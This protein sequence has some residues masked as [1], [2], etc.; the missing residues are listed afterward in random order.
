MNGAFPCGILAG[1]PRPRT[2]REAWQE[3]RAEIPAQIAALQR[4]LATTPATHPER[5]E[6][7]TGRSAA[8]SSAWPSLM[9]GSRR[10]REP[11]ET[12]ARF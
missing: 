5:R 9:P 2:E 8:P 7:L 10:P 12:G 1:M 3:E 11:Y 6:A 4:D